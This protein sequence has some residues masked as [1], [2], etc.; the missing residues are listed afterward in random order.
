MTSWLK[1]I[2]G[3]VVA[4]ALVTVLEF[5]GAASVTAVNPGPNPD[6]LAVTTCGVPIR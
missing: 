4:V 5:I 2:A 6:K 3:G 1:I